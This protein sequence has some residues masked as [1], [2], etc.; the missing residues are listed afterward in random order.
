MCC[1]ENRNRT[2]VPTRCAVYCVLCVV[3]CVPCAVCCVVLRAN[4]GLILSFFLSST[5]RYAGFVYNLLSTKPDIN[6]IVDF[7]FYPNQNQNFTCDPSSTDA[8]KSYL[9]EID[10]FEACAVDSLGCLGGGCDAASQL[11]LFTFLNCFE[12]RQRATHMER[13][14]WSR[15]Q[16]PPSH[17]SRGFDRVITP[18]ARAGARSR[19]WGQ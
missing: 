3:C 6:A 18:G 1:V 12:V 2:R 15:V 4:T 14:S 17:S 5:A 16:P 10:H 8:G 9:C 19:C 13:G 7:A 11:K